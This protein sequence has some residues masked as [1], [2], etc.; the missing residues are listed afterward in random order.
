[1][2]RDT[3]M[4]L[5]PDKSATSRSVG[6]GVNVR[7]SD[8]CPTDCDRLAPANGDLPD[9]AGNRGEADSGALEFLGAVLHHRLPVGS[10]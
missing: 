10:D 2:T 9:T 5:T 6:F 3:V 8:D 7:A 4:M 1:M